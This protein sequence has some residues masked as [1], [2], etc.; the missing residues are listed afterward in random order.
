VRGDQG[1]GEL[2]PRTVGH[3]HRA[4]HRMLK[5]AARQLVARNVAGD[6]ELPSVP[7]SEMATLT[8][9]Q[10]KAMLG[11]AE[12]AIGRPW[13]HPLALL[14]VA[15]SARLG[16]LLALTWAD[17]D[18][19]TGTVRI[20]RSNATVRHFR[21]SVGGGGGRESNPPGKGRSPQRF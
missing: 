14:G 1:P 15:T 16:E 5:Q 11:A 4:V 12:A 19:D 2:A 3:V 9:Q 8:R 21:C 13:L 6:L 17:V 18:L 7:K 20:G 10:A